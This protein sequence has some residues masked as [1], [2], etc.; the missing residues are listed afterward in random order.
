MERVGILGGT[1]N[2]P[3][4][5]HLLM[6]ETA[7]QQHGLSRVIWVPTYQ[8]PHRLPEELIAFHHRLAMVQ[9]A[10]ASHAAFQTVAMEHLPNWS[11]AMHTLTTL[12]Q[13][14]PQA[15]WFWIIG[16]DA[17]QS[18]PRWYGRQT[19][20]TH[21]HWLVA[22]RLQDRAQTIAQCEV[23]A[24]AMQAQALPLRWSV[25]DMPRLDISSRLIRRYVGDRRSI[26]YL[27]TD[28]VRD[29]I[30]THTL[31]QTPAGPMGEGASAGE[32]QTWD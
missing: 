22:P 11:Y 30:H 27:V 14:N 2:P 24:Q 31:Y 6:A 9:G 12:Q 7:H 18:L 8:P 21:C 26:R 25:L 10:I 4:L 19:L 23:V 28:A 32:S 20:V 5:G 13:L 17:F 16:L 1:F 3:H 15:S 29:Y